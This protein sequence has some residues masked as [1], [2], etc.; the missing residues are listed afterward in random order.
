MKGSN[1]N[2]DV[3]VLFSPDQT[4]PAS[5]TRNIIVGG[6]RSSIRLEEVFWDSLD[7]ILQRENLTLNDLVSRIWDRLPARGNLSGAVRVFVH[8]YFYA[9]SQN[10]RPKPPS[11]PNRTT[12]TRRN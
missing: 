6:A 8:N 4:V 7:E 12:P 11:G 2:R 5:R 10:R 1:D 3:A 9:L